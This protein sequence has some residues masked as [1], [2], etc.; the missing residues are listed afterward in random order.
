[1]PLCIG[2]GRN[3]LFPEISTVKDAT[4]RDGQVYAD[5]ASGKRCDAPF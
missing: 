2:N 4:V 5:H 1:M 3:I